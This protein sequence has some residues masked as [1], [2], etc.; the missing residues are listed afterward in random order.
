[1]KIE[2]TGCIYRIYNRI[3]GKSYIGATV[4][5]ETRIEEHFTGRQSSRKLIEAVAEYNID[6]FDWEII[7]SNIE[8]DRLKQ[9]EIHY[10]CAFNT[11][12]PNGYN[13]KAGRTISKETRHRLSEAQRK[14][15]GEANQFYGRRHTSESK[16]KMA[17]SQKGVLRSPESRKKQ[18][19][20]ITGRSREDHSKRMRQLWKTPE[21]R[22]KQRKA[23]S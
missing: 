14:K 23:K 7:E 15:T 1:M 19:E 22:E 13:L 16:A 4:R 2:H 17:Q 3:N 9:M 21:Y 20:S 8:I 12:S 11:L 5:K 6:A 10:I 18:S